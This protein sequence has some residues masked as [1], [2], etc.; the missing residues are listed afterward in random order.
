MTFEAIIKQ[1][2]GQLYRLGF[3]SKCAGLAQVSNTTAGTGTGQIVSAQVWPFNTGGMVSISPDRKESGICFFRASPTR[4]TNQNVW[5]R[6]Q[7]NDVT[8]VVWINGDK[9]KPGPDADYSI[10]IQNHLKK[11]RIEL[12][13][14]S[15][16]RTATIDILGDSLG[17]VVTG[18]GWDASGFKYHESPHQLFQV[19]LRVTSTVAQGCHTAT[20]NVINPSC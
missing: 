11:Y 4:I 20:V 6:Q 1:L 16:I 10:I 15:P 5:L 2:S 18:Y 8:L 3:L 13:A 19:R 14:G 12:E 9:A 17:E 7:E